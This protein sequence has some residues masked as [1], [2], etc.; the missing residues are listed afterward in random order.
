[1]WPEYRSALDHYRTTLKIHSTIYRAFKKQVDA[2]PRLNLKN[3]ATIEDMRR[4]SKLFSKRFNQFSLDGVRLRDASDNW[5]AEGDKLTRIRD[6]ILEHDA[7]GLFG[8]GTK[9]AAIDTDDAEAEFAHFADPIR[10]VLADIDRMLGTDF[11]AVVLPD[12]YEE[13]DAS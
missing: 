11:S 2:D 9:L 12:E 8:V 6:Q 10:S 5:N 7:E 4:R 13:D 1:L 3:A